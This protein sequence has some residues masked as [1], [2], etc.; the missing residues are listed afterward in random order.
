MK[1]SGCYLIIFGGESGDDGLL[2]L[3]KKSLTV[4]KNYEGIRLT[5]DAGILAQS[6]FMLGLP[7][8]TRE[9]TM[10]TIQFALDS[11]LDY[12]LFPITEPYPGT[13][14]WIDA[15]RYGTFDTSGKYRNNLLSEN[16]AVWIPQG[17]T[18][19]ELETLS[20]YAMRRFYLRPRQIWRG[21][22]NF[23]Y[24]PPGRAFRYFAAGVSYFG[25]KRS[26][27]VQGGTRF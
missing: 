3:I 14:L 15:K 7:T 1:Q 4:K 12:A 2:K 19:E 11:G 13:E 9:Q 21:V 8:E 17:R 10:K 6:S 20:R 26:N 22:L 5:K 18:R 24:L 27:P 16:S 25:L 23:F